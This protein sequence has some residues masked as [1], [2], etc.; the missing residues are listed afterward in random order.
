MVT[1]NTP[2]C[3]FSNVINNECFFYD[4][5]EKYK[6]IN[7]LAIQ[8]ENDKHFNLI[9]QFTTFIYFSIFIIIRYF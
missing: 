7:R 8:Y 4:L 1:I 2:S 9:L 5:N 6:I 3:K